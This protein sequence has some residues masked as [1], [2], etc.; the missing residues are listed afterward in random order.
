[1]TGE[2]QTER[3]PLQFD[4]LLE[5]LRLDGGPQGRLA[6]L[7]DAAEQVADAERRVSRLLVRRLQGLV[8]FTEQ[9]GADQTQVL[10][11][12]A[13][14]IHGPRMDQGLDHALVGPLD[15]NPQA[16]RGQALKAPVLAPFD[17]RFAGLDNALHRHPPD[18]AH[19]AQSVD[20]VAVDD[21][22]AELA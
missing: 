5:G 15:V 8:E 10:A 12:S 3:A 11:R 20:D 9:L 16:K 7:A 17:S 19:R 2:V 4:P 1:M 13:Q 6:I 22:E 21:R 18:A 14:L